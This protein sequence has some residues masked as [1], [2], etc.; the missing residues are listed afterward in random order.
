MNIDQLA[1][2]LHDSL[3]PECIGMDRDAER[4]KQIKAA[5]EKALLAH[6][7]KPFRA[8]QART[9]PDIITGEPI[10][11]VQERAAQSGEVRPLIFDPEHY[12]E[13][14]AAHE[15]AKRAAQAEHGN[16]NTDWLRDYQHHDQNLS[17][18]D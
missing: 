7:I 16:C 15:V 18:E 3:F 13:D 14:R 8:A 11:F 5:I 6:G 10:E 12:P 4:M 17:K 9:A 1:A 2:D